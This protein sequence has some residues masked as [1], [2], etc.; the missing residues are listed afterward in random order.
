[1]KLPLWENKTNAHNLINCPHLKSF[2]TGYPERN[3]HSQSTLLLREEFEERWQNFKIMEPEFLLFL[4][5]LE[6]GNEN[7]PE[8]LQMEL[9]CSTIISLARSF[10]KQNCK[11]YLLF[12]NVTQR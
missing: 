1:M 6:T 12:W 8:N 4:L 10:L 3:P 11:K 7:A 5:P 2:D 9:T